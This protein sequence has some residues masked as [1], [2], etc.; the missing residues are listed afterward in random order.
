MNNI[1]Y[2]KYLLTAWFLLGSSIVLPR[3]PLEGY[4]IEAA[5]NNPGLKSKFSKY[6]AAL[7]KVPQVGALPDPQVTFGYLIQPVETRVGP[8][9]A[10][11]SAMQMFPWFGTLNTKEDAAMEMAKSK[12]E[13]F[14]DAKARLFYNVKS[15]Y[16][17]LY[18]TGKAID[19]TVENI[20]ILN[21][22]RQ[23][24]LIKLESGLVSSVDV[25]RVE[26]EIADMENQLAS[27]KD[28]YF[29]MQA[30][31]NNLLNVDE[32]RSVIIPDSLDN[33]DF[34][35]TREAALDSIRRGNHQVL[36]LE[37][38]EA[39]YEKKEIL[40]RKTGKPNLMLGFNYMA[41]GKSTNPM[42]DP[43]ESGRDA[44]VFPIV[45]I[46][47]PLYRQ[48]YTSMVKEAVLMQESVDNSKLDKINI[49]ETSYEKTNKDYKDA[50]RRIPLYQGQSGKASKALNILQTEYETNGKNFEEVLRIERQLLKYRLELE[51]ARADKSAAI[52]FITYL[53][54]K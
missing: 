47:I 48:K 51:K 19:I 33:I 42:T 14:E 31:F 23:L 25:L 46:S 36:Q 39:S 43:S 3:D 5:N 32:Q 2:I 22:F 38:I 24:A 6:M 17:N 54:G 10:R 26:I 4:L 27:L 16:Y 40:A 7:E 21:T 52:A 41:I 13:M 45:G 53:M 35:L 30:G 29:F 12:Y 15:T 11:I 9:Q 37:F 20:D 18:F 44:F 8:Q 49:L 50:D 28:N 34:E 1:K